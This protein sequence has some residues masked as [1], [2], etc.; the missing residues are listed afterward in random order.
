VQFAKKLNRSNIVRRRTRKRENNMKKST[1]KLILV[2]MFMLLAIS[3]ISMAIDPSANFAQAATPSTIVTTELINFYSMTNSEVQTFMT[4][5]HNQGISTLTVRINSYSEWT[6]NSNT[7]IAK[8]KAIIPVANAQGISINVDLHTWFTT[9]DNSFRDSASNSAANRNTYINYVKTTLQAFNGYN[10]NTFMVLNEPQARTA[11]TSENNFILSIIS[12]AN[13]VTNRP[14]SVRFMAGYSPSTGHYSSAIDQATDFLC[15]NS[16]WDARNPSVSVYGCTETKLLTALSNAHNQNKQLWITEFGKSN[17]NLADQ[18]SYVRAF[19]AYAKS[20]GID[21][22]FCWVSQPES[23]GEDYNIF[24]GYT[25]NPA[26]YELVSNDAANPFPS[27]SPTPTSTPTPTQ[28]PQPTSTPT[29]SPSP[30]PTRN[31]YWRHHH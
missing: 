20:K 31:P 25:P 8:I 17:S 1:L 16:Y 30:S 3:Q 4:T 11:S 13:S 24:N 10:V 5:L 21:Q 23:S 6:G 9:W 19:V 28:T 2:T 12:A 15:R 14:I 22:I 7:A 27:S 18:Q 29:P 26:F